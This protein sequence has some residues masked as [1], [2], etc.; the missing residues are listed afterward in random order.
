MWIF[1]QQVHPLH[2]IFIYS[3]A[4][5]VVI[6]VQT[7]VRSKRQKEVR[8]E[9]S[10]WRFSLNAT[11]MALLLFTEVRYKLKSFSIRSKCLVFHWHSEE[12]IFWSF[13]WDLRDKKH[14]L[15]WVLWPQPLC[16]L[17][18]T[19]PSLRL[20]LHTTRAVIRRVTRMGTTMKGPRMRFGGSLRSRPDS[21]Q[22]WK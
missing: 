8:Y 10:P 1:S 4:S 9:P 17:Y 6:L 16:S 5:P 7:R 18:Y 2:F 21:E 3:I 15:S 13:L 12:G 20:L 11:V 14:L 19:I 22:S